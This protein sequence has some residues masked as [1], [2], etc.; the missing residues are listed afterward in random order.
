MSSQLHLSMDILHNASNNDTMMAMMI[1]D[2]SEATAS[3]QP[4]SPPSSVDFKP[5]PIELPRKPGMPFRRC[6]H[7]R[8]TRPDHAGCS[9]TLTDKKMRDKVER[10]PQ[11]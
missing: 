8:V 6:C 3:H 7:T 4:Q 5:I 9:A 10:D 2:V 11:A 1:R